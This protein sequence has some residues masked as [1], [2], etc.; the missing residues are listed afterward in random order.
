MFPSRIRRGDLLHGE[1]VALVG[2]LITACIA[3]EKGLLSD[4]ELARLVGLFHGLGVPL[5]NHLLANRRLIESGLREAVKHRNG[6]IRFALPDGIGGC[7]FDDAISIETVLAA[8]GELYEIARHRH[9]L[10]SPYES[11]RRLTATSCVTR[12]SGRS[13]PREGRAALGAQDPILLALPTTTKSAPFR[14]HNRK[15]SWPT[16]ITVTLRSPHLRLTDRRTASSGDTGELWHLRVSQPNVA[17]VP[18][19]AMHSVEHFLLDNMR[20]ASPAVM[21]AA[22]MGV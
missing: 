22:P 8:I 3:R 17:H 1:A 11:P 21:L 20:A 19:D 7:R 10:R 15:S 13:G 4:S 12:R 16:S 14:T 5:W 2:I 18:P 6:R 9:G